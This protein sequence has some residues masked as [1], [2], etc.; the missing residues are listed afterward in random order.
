MVDMSI[1]ALNG[2]IALPF[3][4][5]AAFFFFLKG[6]VIAAREPLS[7]AICTYEI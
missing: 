3:V 1:S 5:T 4:G 7:R 2:L 6:F